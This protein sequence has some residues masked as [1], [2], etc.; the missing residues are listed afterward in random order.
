[1]SNA[2]DQKKIKKRWLL[3]GSLMFVVGISFAVIFDV[4]IGSTNTTEFCI[5][6]HSMRTNFLELQQT[7]HWKGVSGVHAGCPDCH[8]P[9]EFF[10]KI[11]AK[12]RAVKDIWHEFIGTIDTPEKFEARREYL[13]NLVW[14]KMKANGS[15]ECLNCHSLEHMDFSLQ[16][17]FARK[18]HERA[19]DKG[20]S[21]IDCHQGIAHKVPATEKSDP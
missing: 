14:E 1:M 13:A 12:V 10:P 7:L 5:S 20:E 4:G 11:I 16:D 8:V 18:K 6:C 17:K 3:F 19:S 21:C 9:K 15:R 2:P